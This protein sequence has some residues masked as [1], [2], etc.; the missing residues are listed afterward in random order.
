MEQRHIRLNFEFPLSHPFNLLER[1]GRLL[2]AISLPVSSGVLDTRCISVSKQMWTDSEA[3]LV[4]VIC[5][6]TQLS[7]IIKQM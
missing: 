3:F 7:T 6:L 5:T 4:S 1:R 2:P